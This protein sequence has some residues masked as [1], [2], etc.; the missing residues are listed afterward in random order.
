MDFLFDYYPYS[1]G[2]LSTWHPG[3]GVGLRGPWKP[4]SSA[5]AYIFD[6]DAW[7]VDPDTVDSARLALALQILQGT[8]SRPAL[9]S[10][11]GMHEWAMVYRIDPEHV[12]HSSQPLRL[13]ID[14]ISETVDHVG[15]RCT[16]ID[17]FRF[18]TDAAAPHNSLTPTRA[19]QPDLEQPGCLH[20]N[21]DLFKYSMW[22]QPYVPGDLVLDCFELAVEVREVDM[23]ASPYDLSN[24]GYPPIRL[25]TPDGRREYAAAQKRSADNAKPLRRRLIEELSSLQDAL[26]RDP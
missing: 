20:A 3:L 13:S 14:E 2:R 12:R 9:L 23:R 25:E 18:F 6:G 15:L 24:L 21:M 11:F 8:Q 26:T 19:N 7:S 22:F 17:A 4:T 10:C 1:P 5:N 16:H